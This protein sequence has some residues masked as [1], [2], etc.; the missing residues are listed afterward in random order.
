MR[1]MLRSFAVVAVG[2]AGLVAVSAP[3]A[4]VVDAERAAVSATV[5]S[6][7]LTG[8]LWVLTS[9]RGKPPI[10]GTQLTSE[11]TTDKAVS[12]SSG[13]NRYSG[14]YSAS[15]NT[16][17]ISSPLASTR[18]ACARP[19][20]LQ[21][22]AFLKALA[23]VRRYDVNDGRLTLKSAA[24]KLILQYKAQ[25]QQL[26]GTSWIVSA[27][28]NGNQGVESVLTG[29]KLTAVFG[30]DGSLSGS[31]GCNNYNGPYKAAA[32]KIA[33]GPLVSTKMHCAEPEG[34]SDQEARFLAALQ[35]AATYQVEGKRLVMRTAAGALAVELTRK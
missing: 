30:K 24:G 20:A 2:S 11:F 1:G 31:A 25:S 29:T 16:I 6:G 14:S 21:E 18:K 35:T 15:G 33:I 23:S 28:N 34:V 3:D 22:A 19:I 32:P 17:R 10:R 5:Q 12:G 13:C 4:R 26:A 8:S 9:L 27:Y 7:S